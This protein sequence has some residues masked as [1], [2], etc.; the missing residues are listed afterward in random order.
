MRSYP[1]YQML[2]HTLPVKLDRTNYILRRSH[3][4]NVVFANG[5]ED[6]IDGTSICPEKD[7]SLGVINPAFV[8]WRRQDRTILSWIYSSLTL[9]IMAQII[10][11]NTS[12]SAWNALESI[13]S[14]SSKARIMQL[15]L[16]LQ[17]TKKGS[18]S[19]IDYIMKVKGAA[20]NLAAIGEPVSEQDQVMNL[21]GGLGSDYNA[22]VT[23]INIRDDKIS[24]EA[25]HSMLLAFEHRLE[26]Q[27]LIEQ[28]SA[29]YASSSN[30]RVVEGSLMEVVDKATLQI[31]IITPI[32]VVDVEVEMDKVEGKIP[33]QVRNLSVNYVTTISHSLNNGNQNNIPAMVA[34]ASNKPA[35]ESWY[36]DSGASHHLTQNLGNLTSTSPYTRTDRVTI[37]NGKHLSISNIGSKQLHSHTHSFQLKKV[38]HVPFISTNLISVAK[39]YSDNNALI[40]F[41]SNAFF[42]KD[43]HTK[44]VL[45]QGKLE[46]GFTSFLC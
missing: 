34:F 14:S 36:L 27:S 4:D 13:F 17:S 40:E 38:F 43:L 10:V 2:N 31:T 11:H 26:Q 8:A 3:I 29:N 25:I 39:F 22:V 28:M 16:E 5:F 6:F 46:M 42:V 19:M 18:M 9:G 33:V 12:H 7:L 30:N 23:A 41:H 20:D 32:E 1:S 24:L 35:D 37:G 45:A 44:M 15:R 21:L